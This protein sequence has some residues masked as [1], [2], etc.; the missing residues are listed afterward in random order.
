[1]KYCA[2]SLQQLTFLL[3]SDEAHFAVLLWPFVRYAF[4]KTVV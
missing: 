1:V 3:W 4:S 2:A